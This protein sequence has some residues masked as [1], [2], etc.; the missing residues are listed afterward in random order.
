M[1]VE[2]SDSILILATRILTNAGYSVASTANGAEAVAMMSARIFD[3]IVVD[4]GLPDMTGLEVLRKARQIQPAI[5]AVLVTG[6]RPGPQMLS[7]VHAVGDD[8]QVLWKPFR[9][10]DLR[11]AVEKARGRGEA[12]PS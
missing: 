12:P 10:E 11:S 7:D 1:V 4:Y 9:A 3:V 2:D 8:V 5:A 6:T